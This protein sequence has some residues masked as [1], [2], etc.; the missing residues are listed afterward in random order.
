M[1]LSLPEYF[2]ALIGAGP[3]GIELA[4]A[5]KQTGVNYVHFEAGQLGQTLTWW[6]HN[7][8]FFS[9]PE[10]IALSGVPIHNPDQQHITGEQYLAYLRSLVEQYQLDIHLYE[11]VVSLERLPAGGFALTSRRQTGEH[12]WRAAKVIL[13]IGGMHAPNRLEIPGE[14]LPHVSHYFDD[15]HRFFRQRLVVVGGGNSAV[16][17]ALRCWR[18]GADVTLSYRGPD[19]NREEIKPFLLAD[20]DTVTREGKMRFLPATAAVEIRPG[21][22]VLAPAGPDGQPVE[23]PCPCLPADFVLLLTGHRMDTT[24]LEQAGVD[25]QGA[26]EMPRHNPLTMETNVPGLFVAGVTVGGSQMQYKHFIETS[27]A[28]VPK[29]VHAITGRRYDL[30]LVDPSSPPSETR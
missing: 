30:P 14:D 22:I 18:A 26:E 24:L 1:D 11:R 4:V 27:H 19:L 17:A 9:S 10:R 13:A 25:M 20:F 8:R 29:I 3:I 15:P 7:T 23:G 16:E 12:R 2:V 28:H 6:P 5:L 21:E